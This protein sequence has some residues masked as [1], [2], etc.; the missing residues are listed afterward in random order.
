MPTSPQGW[1]TRKEAAEVA[2]K[3]RRVGYKARVSKNKIKGY[4]RVIFQEVKGE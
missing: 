3:L 1:E 2:R 4:Y